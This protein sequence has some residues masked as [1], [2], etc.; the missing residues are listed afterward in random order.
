MK[1]LV[2]GATGFIG[3][4]VVDA[5][6]DQGYEVR[7]LVRP[8]TPSGHLSD[9]GVEVVSGDVTDFRSVWVAARQVDAVLHLAA[10]YSMRPGPAAYER[11]NVEGTRNV[12][13]ACVESG[14][15]AVHCSSIVAV[16]G[17]TDPGRAV[18]EDT[19]W[20]LGATGDP[21]ILSKRRSEEEVLEM[22]AAG[23]LDVVI[24]NPTGP[25]G[26]RD[27]KPTPTGNLL[28]M[29]LNGLGR[30]APEGGINLV[31]VADVAAGHVLALTR[32]RTGQR[33]I[34]A[35][36]NLTTLQMLNR[37]AAV[38][39][40]PGPMAVVPH[41]AVAVAAAG[42]ELVARLTGGDPLMTRATARVSRFFLFASSDKA[43]VELGYAPASVDAAI[44]GAARWFAANGYLKRRAAARVLAR[45]GGP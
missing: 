39:G 26:P 34:L 41:P 3:G 17:S 18:D 24:V 19:D 21:Y 15:R 36:E 22:C 1:V 20:N 10:L 23:S 42:A 37:F 45:L 44:A 8:V 14:A 9:R 31:D 40:C 30:V 33:Y 35:G 38:T 2:T 25:V 27:V 32:G 16:G 29:C 12:M 6:L 43:C 5:C 28:V 7:A 11:A 4:H 13:R